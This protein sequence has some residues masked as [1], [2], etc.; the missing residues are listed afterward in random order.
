MGGSMND[1]SSHVHEKLQILRPTGIVPTTTRLVRSAL[2]RHKLVEAADACS[3]PN[4]VSYHGGPLIRNV[5]IFAFYWGSA[6]SEP[7]LAGVADNMNAFLTEF[8]RGEPM[9]QLAEY[10]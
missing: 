6:W 3:S 10:S 9:D 8:A 2:K 1:S 5:E 7:G 4:R